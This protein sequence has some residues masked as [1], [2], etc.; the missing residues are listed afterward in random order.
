MTDC[1][2]ADAA[3]RLRHFNRF[4]TAQIGVLDRDLLGSGRS[5][6]EARVLYELAQA[7][8][9][10]AVE[11]AKVLAMDA[12]FL[13]RM[14]AR[15]EREGLIERRRSRADGRVSHLALTGAGRAAFADLDRLSQNAGEALLSPLPDDERGE[16]LS[17][18]RRVETILAP[19]PK[20]ED[21]V[22]RAHRTGDMG[23]IIHRQALLYEREYGWDASYEALVAEITSQFLRNFNPGR[24]YCWIA[25]R[26]GDILGSVFLVRESDEI[27]KLR[28]LYVERAARGLGV[29][30]RL[31][32]ECI[33]FARS[34]G[35][36]RLDLWTNSVLTAARALYEQAGFRLVR[37]EAHR[38]FGKDLVG[39]FWT[40][41][42]DDEAND[43]EHA[44]FEPRG[45]TGHGMRG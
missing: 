44:D 38:S 13:S 30:R 3:S 21:V 20:P 31:V 43:G 10:T 41:P 39:Q 35:Y 29:G 22:L 16:L 5:L 11:L 17:S 1:S 28:L 33:G 27:A 12:G 6:A 7:E 40:L 32:N 14:L 26:G 42:L 25:E 36:A 8:T 19:A 23:W 4:Y 15:F 34:A 2:L 45:G 18:M 9:V 24:E 37:E